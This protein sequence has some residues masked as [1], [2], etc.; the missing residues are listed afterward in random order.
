MT[1]KLPKLLRTLETS[2]EAMGVHPVAVAR[3]CGATLRPRAAS[4]ILAA[5]NDTG[6]AGGPP[7]HH[8]VSQCGFAAEQAFDVVDQNINDVLFVTLG[9]A[10]G[11]G[12]DHHVRQ[13]PEGGFSRER[14]LREAI[15]RGGA[16]PPF[17]ERVEQRHMV[18]HLAARNID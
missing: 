3:P 14:F 13:R 10:C 18:D 9:F 2:T 15:E 12:R 7:S 17:G 1:S 4:K 8:L 11:M 16:H 5:P 6:Y